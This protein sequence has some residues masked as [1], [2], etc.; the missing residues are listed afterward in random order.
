MQS[1][2]SLWIGRP[3]SKI[4]IASLMSYCI[5]KHE[6]NLFCYDEVKNIPKEI[7]V[8]DAREVLPKKYLTMFDNS[9]S[10]FSDWFRYK[11]MQKYDFFWTDLDSICLTPNWNFRDEYVFGINDKYNKKEYLCTSSFKLPK[12]SEVLEYL[13]FSASR[14]DMSK[15]WAP[16][17]PRLLTEAIF[18]YNLQNKILPPKAFSPIPF[19]NWKSLWDQDSEEV[20][21]TLTSKSYTIQ[22]WNQMIN[23]SGIDRENPQKGSYIKFIYDNF[24]I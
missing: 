23:R 12:D 17:G 22:L 24:L 1:F 11:M 19:Y 10:N 15:E 7:N 14:A 8:I 3:L 6:I 13:V 16:A 5:N 21:K 20:V 18:K 2:G 9:Y 4:E